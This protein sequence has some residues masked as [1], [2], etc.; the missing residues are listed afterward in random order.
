MPRAKHPGQGEEL[1]WAGELTAPECGP[2]KGMHL[3]PHTGPIYRSAN[4]GPE[5]GGHWSKV[6]QWACR[7]AG[8]QI[9]PESVIFEAG[10]CPVLAGIHV[11]VDSLYSYCLAANQARRTWLPPRSSA[12]PLGSQRRSQGPGQPALEGAGHAAYVSGPFFT[13]LVSGSLCGCLTQEKGNKGAN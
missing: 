7:R 2:S 11:A 4:Q 6:A 8:H 3:H 12:C 5:R 9:I 1:P 10:Q 13:P